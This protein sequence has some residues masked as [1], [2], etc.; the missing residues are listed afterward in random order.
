ML[1]R[2]QI[3]FSADYARENHQDVMYITERAVFRLVDGG[4]ELIEI[5][6]GVD[7]ERDVL[8]KMDFRPKISPDLK[9]MD[10]RI[11]NEAIMGI[12]DEIV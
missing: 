1:F 2:S 8:G 7:L 9:L 10:A 11:F 3:T 4:I 6:P 12:K 5:A